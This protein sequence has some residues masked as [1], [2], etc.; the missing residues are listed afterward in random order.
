VVETVQDRYAR[1]GLG[2]CLTQHPGLYIVP[3]GAVELR[4]QGELVVNATGPDGMTIDDAFWVELDVPPDFPKTPANA[5]EVG[6]RIPQNYHKLKGNRLCLGSPTAIRLELGKSPT[7]VGFVERLV[8]PYLFGFAY[9]ER[10]GRMPYGE[11]A[12]GLEGIRQ[13]FAELFRLPSIASADE[14]VRLASLPK[15][16]ANKQL[17]PCGGGRRLGSCHHLVV[18]RYRKQ[19][20][21]AWFRSEHLYL[22]KDDRYF[23]NSLG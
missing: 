4:L 18:N 17:C 2:E 11:L 6:G 5:R 22:T 3:T 1:W 15:R 23:S 9:F 21:R 8:V 20:G 10:F 19:L 7:L 13:H 14:M 12:H 16:V